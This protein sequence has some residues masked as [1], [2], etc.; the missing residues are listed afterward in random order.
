MTDSPARPRGR[1][2]GRADTRGTICRAALTL[3]S[4]IGYDKV[5]LRAI[6]READVDP[7]LIHHY[8]SSKS[9]LFAQT[10]L[11]LPLDADRLVSDVLA[12]PRDQIGQAAVAAFL[13]AYDG[14]DGGRERFTAMLRSAVAEEVVQRPMSEFMSKEVFG[15]IAERLGHVNFKLRGQLAVS[16]VLGMALSRYILRLPTLT[17]ASDQMIIEELRP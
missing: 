10:V 3:F 16:L 6:A 12:G 17:A 11:D 13:A 4:T 15:A 8:F 2:P 7:A 14:P 5:S 1:R 9:D